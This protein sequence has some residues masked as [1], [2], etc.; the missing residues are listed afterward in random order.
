MMSEFDI[1]LQTIVNGLMQGGLYALIAI[2]LT[3]IYGVMKV[4]NFSHG[5]MLMLGMYGAFW[6]FALANIIPYVSVFFVFG[7]MFGI[8]ALIQR[9][10]IGKVIGSEP[11][12]TLM[13]TIG[14]STIFSS[15]AQFFWQANVRTLHLPWG[16]DSLRIGDIRFTYTR[17]IAFA[18]SILLVLAL[19]AFLK[20]S[21]TGK[22]MRAASQN[23][24]AATLMG[25]NVR[26]VYIIAFGLG[27]GLAGVAGVLMAPFQPVSPMIGSQFAIIAFVVVVLGTMGNFVGALVGGILIG[28]AEAIGGYIFGTQAKLLVSLLIFMLVLLFKPSGLFG[29]KKK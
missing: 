15:T 18:A 3:M 22:A 23:R 28:V 2:G 7:I 5:D 10:F 4:T 11:M 6:F 17:L 21:R 14:I 25:I 13:V 1:V 24:E 26:A 12:N 9:F 19:F 29:G 16:L 8:G 20:Y 27:S